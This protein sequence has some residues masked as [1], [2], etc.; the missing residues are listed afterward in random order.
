MLYHGS[1]QSS[2]TPHNNCLIIGYRRLSLGG[3]SGGE[4]R[5]IYRVE[6]FPYISANRSANT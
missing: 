5:Y 1:T 3:I 4:T 2:V 6:S